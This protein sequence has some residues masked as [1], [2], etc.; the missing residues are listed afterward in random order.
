MQNIQTTTETQPTLADY[1]EMRAEEVQ[2][3]TERAEQKRQQEAEDERERY[4]TDFRVMIE[5]HLP[6]G[7]HAALNLSEPVYTSD[8]DSDHGDYY[9]KVEASFTHDGEIW[10]LRYWGGHLSVIDPS[11]AQIRLVDEWTAEGWICSGPLLDVIQGYPQRQQ[12]AQKRA[13]EAAA[14]EAQEG[15]AAEAKPAG[16]IHYTSAQGSNA[17]HSLLHPGAYVTIWYASYYG[18]YTPS[19]WGTVESWDKRWL[20]LTNPNGKQ[21]LIAWRHVANVE[22]RDPAQDQPEPEPEPE[23]TRYSDDIPF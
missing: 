11:G 13:D 21:Q 14:C 20:L 17:R 4:L 22:P 1:L 5:R 3:A 18:E 15:A 7:L 6:P 9:T 19:S 12:E 2:Q 16:P 8:R 23:P 10:T